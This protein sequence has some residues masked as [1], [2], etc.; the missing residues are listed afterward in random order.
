MVNKDEG[1]KIATELCHSDN[2][3]S[4]VVRDLTSE[5]LHRHDLPPDTIKLLLNALSI[6]I[7]TFPVTLPSI[8][9]PYCLKGYLQSY[10]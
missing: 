1:D 9:L 3:C 2:P 10:H 5:S 8:R 7:P 6:L 4:Q